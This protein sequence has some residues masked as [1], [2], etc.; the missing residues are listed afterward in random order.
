MYT[1]AC[2]CIHDNTLII[3]YHYRLQEEGHLSTE[4]RDELWKYICCYDELGFDP[5]G[6]SKKRTLSLKTKKKKNKLGKKVEKLFRQQVPCFR[7][8]HS[9]ECM[10]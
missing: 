1:Y 10:L 9:I 7:G 6:K 5:D 2:V 4:Q 8:A 3:N